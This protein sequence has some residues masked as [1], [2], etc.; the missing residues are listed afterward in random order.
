MSVRRM[1]PKGPS[2]LT[3]FVKLQETKEGGALET[4]QREEGAARRGAVR[5]KGTEGQGRAS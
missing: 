3:G 1:R 5:V 4:A 2:H